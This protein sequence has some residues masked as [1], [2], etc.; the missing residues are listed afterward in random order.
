MNTA[1]INTTKKK[2]VLVGMS[3]GVDSAVAAYLLQKEGHDVCGVTLRTLDTE[4]RCCEIDDA[5][6][7]AWKLGIRFYALNCID[8]FSAKVV[9]PFVCAYLRGLTP[10]PC[11]ECNRFVKWEKMLYA[12]RVMEADYVATGHYASVVRLSNGCWTVRKAVHAAKDQTYMLYRL[13]QEQLAATR[14][15]LGGY[16]KEQVRKIAEEAGLPVADKPDS[17][18]ICF[19]TDG[20]YADFIEQYVQKRNDSAPAGCSPWT[21]PGPGAFVDE[22]ENRLGTHK[23]ITHY[24]VGQRKGLGISMGHPV[25]VKEIR[26][27]S[28]EVVLSTEPSLYRDVVLCRDVNFLSIPGLPPGETL[29]AKTKIRYHHVAADSEI[30]LLEDGCVRIRFDAP[31]RA[32]APGQSAVFYDDS[33]C[34][35]GGGIIL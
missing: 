15:P 33:D 13:T 31:V 23:G 7:A 5:R 4:G 30:Q 29:R 35:I 17:Q 3:G 6:R 22:D 26:A 28:D 25:Y 32:A 2:R 9:D 8:D 18:E 19:V 21:V 14:M 16:S 10:N 24:T 12:A 34:V 1:F 11:I 27:A 20:H